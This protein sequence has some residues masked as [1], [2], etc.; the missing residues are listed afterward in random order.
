M[1]TEGNTDVAQLPTR[2]MESRAA[3]AGF[4]ET[5]LHGK[6]PRIQIF[7]L[8]ELFAGKRPVIPNVSPAMFKAAPEEVGQAKLDF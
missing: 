7:T 6:V 3:A 4:F 1:L 5:G 8:A 2:E